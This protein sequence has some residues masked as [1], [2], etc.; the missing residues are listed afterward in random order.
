MH[1][2]GEIVRIEAQML[3]WLA[4][5]ILFGALITPLAAQPRHADTGPAPSTS[6]NPSPW[7]PDYNEMAIADAHIHDLQPTKA[8]EAQLRQ[9]A[10]GTRRLVE[11]TL[12]TEHRALTDAERKK[13][14]VE[15]RKKAKAILTPQQYKE[16]C[17]YEVFILFSRPFHFE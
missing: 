13:I 17:E 4:P 5:V 3:R 6:P 9:M 7:P 11:D 2:C 10:V 12:K 14:L 1:K 16:Y 8:Q 15:S